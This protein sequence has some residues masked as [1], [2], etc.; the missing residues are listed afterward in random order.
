MVL[1][2][3]YD[4]FLYPLSVL[5]MADCNYNKTLKKINFIFL[6]TILTNFMKVA[7]RYIDS[8]QKHFQKI[9]KTK[10]PSKARLSR[11]RF[12]FQIVSIVVNCVLFVMSVYDA[13]FSRRAGGDPTNPLAAPEGTTINNPGFK[14]GRGKLFFCNPV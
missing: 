14:D 1:F 4:K 11:Y 5:I 9:Y 10:I 2:V 3:V 6:H 8:N 13:L 12:Y 7:R